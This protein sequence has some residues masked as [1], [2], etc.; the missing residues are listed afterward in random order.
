MISPM[1]IEIDLLE[2]LL[3]ARSASNV[4]G[5]DLSQL[6]A[7]VGL[8]HCSTCLPPAFLGSLMLL[9]GMVL[10]VLAI[11]SPGSPSLFYPQHTYF[12]NHAS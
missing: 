4:V 2:F 8:S 5:I 3:S 10:D 11:C 12:F 9:S 6:K 7:D 1:V